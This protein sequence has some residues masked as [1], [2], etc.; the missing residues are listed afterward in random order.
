MQQKKTPGVITAYVR[1]KDPILD[2]LL[3]ELETLKATHGRVVGAAG[4]E[5]MAHRKTQER[6]ETALA[7]ARHAEK[8]LDQEKAASARLSLVISW[9]HHDLRTPL[10]V[11]IGYAPML[12]EALSGAVPKGVD[13]KHL[14]NRIERS[15]TRMH[16][17][18]D[19]ARDYLR[20]VPGLLQIETGRVDLCGEAADAAGIMGQRAAEKGLALEHSH[21][22]GAYAVVDQKLLRHALISLIRSS[23]ACA[24]KGSTVTLAAGAADGRATI[25]VSDIGKAVTKEEMAFAFGTPEAGESIG[26][27]D[28]RGLGLIV[29]RAFTERMGGTVSVDSAEGTTTVTMAFP[30]AQQ[31]QK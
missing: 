4:D 26:E 8:L 12:S 3:T 15:G 1:G 13:P 11:V 19:M 25:S 14:A 5:M 6:L 29:A 23:I 10:T 21:A 30:L 20:L 22:S 9:I 2:T 17:A 24:P 27:T 16:Q 18:L 7:S 31:A 28:F